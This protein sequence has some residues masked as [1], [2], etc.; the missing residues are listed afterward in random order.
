[1]IN[2]LGLKNYAS[3]GFG[4]II[5]L[6]TPIII[7][8]KLIS[9]CGLNNWGKIAVAISIFLIINIFIDFGNFLTGI[10]T[11][12]INKDNPNK[13]TEYLTAIYNFKLVMLL[14]V[15]LIFGITIIL[16]NQNLLLYLFGLIYL[17][18]LATNPIWY[19]QA[20]E[21]YKTINVIILIS[22]ILQ[23]TLIYSFIN[24]Q[25][26][27]VF[28][29]LFLGISNF[30]VNIFF[31]KRVFFEND[32]KISKNIFKNFKDV[33]KKE[34]SIV[35]SNLSISLYVNVP[36]MIISSVLGNYETGI[37]KIAEMLLG[38]LRSFLSV[39]FAVSF[40]RFCKMYED[41]K[42]EGISFL[43]LT[44]KIN[45]TFLFSLAC[46]I[47][48]IYFFFPFENY[49]SNGSISIIDFVV[50]VVFIPFIIAINIPFY[51]L[52][53]YYSKEKYL[54]Y[55][56]LMGVVLMFASCY[57]LSIIFNLTGS[58]ISL[59]LVE[60]FMSSSIIIYYF[61]FIQSKKN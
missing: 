4:Q 23:I 2:K 33:F 19:F 55:I 22:R 31:L 27:Y 41:N 29:F 58:L 10:K 42:K 14:T 3:Y 54:S 37:Y 24:S 13:I 8:P 53:L 7:A 6:L 46:L 30:I 57:F 51:Q 38:L 40:P 28:Y 34:I 49:F 45:I 61:K 1:M 16:L 21:D 59:Y 56:S 36:I 12:S 26:D 43:K 9:V 50:K 17:I 60:I 18:A 47:L 39:F 35:M 32:V 11:I 20:L 15:L 48:V 52:L 5:S 44:T 25:N